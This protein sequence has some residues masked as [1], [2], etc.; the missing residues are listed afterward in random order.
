MT[1]WDYE[2]IDCEGLDF[3]KLGQKGW[4]LVSVSD[5]TAYF[6]R[7]VIAVTGNEPIIL[8]DYDKAAERIMEKKLN[9]MA[10]G[11]LDD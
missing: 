6:K 5:G 2:I 7:P 1:K 4:E 8:G 9:R 10:E 3:D 11:R